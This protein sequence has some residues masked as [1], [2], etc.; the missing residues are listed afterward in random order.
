MG[1]H[2]TRWAPEPPEGGSVGVDAHRDLMRV[3]GVQVDRRM[4]RHAV[5]RTKA[6]SV[7]QENIQN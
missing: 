7:S 5:G 3:E 4:R 6:Q 2:E 1:P